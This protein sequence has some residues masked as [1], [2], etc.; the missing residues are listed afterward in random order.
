M[1]PVGDAAVATWVAD[2][3]HPFAQDVGSVVPSGFEAYTRAFHPAGKGVGDDWSAV[4]WS[5]IAEANQK[6]PHPEMQFESIVPQDCFE[7]IKS[8]RKGQPGLWDWPP[9]DGEL[10]ED[11]ARDLS[12]VLKDH[13]A[14]PELCYFAYWDGWGDPMIA[15]A[16]TRDPQERAE[17]QRIE[18]S[19]RT[20]EVFA[21]T[22]RASREQAVLLSIP[23]RDFYLFEGT[24]AEVVTGWDGISDELPSMWWPSDR[25]WCVATEIDLDSTYVGGSRECIAALTSH[26]GI[27]ALEAKV[28]HGIVRDPM[29]R[30]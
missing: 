10:P 9:D 14:T 26:R 16:P 21:G 30:P 27:E 18:E 29:N 19:Y 24:I 15:F 4:R 23:G 13:T 20:G 6:V 7:G 12:E 17:Q 5:D 3:A 22:P 28:S 2:R 11:L 8:W 1:K 25:A